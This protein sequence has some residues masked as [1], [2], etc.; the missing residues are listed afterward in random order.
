MLYTVPEARVALCKCSETNQTYG[1]RF[2]KSDDGWKY[3]W[4][5]KIKESSA[6]RENYD[7]TVLQG[8]LTLGEDYPGCPY[9]GAKYFIVCT[10]GK[11]SCNSINRKSNSV[12]CE[13]CGE[14]G[15]ITDYYG[16]GVDSET[17]R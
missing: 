13:W 10:C 17:D 11:L 1:V 14:T 4:A 5:F 3:T 6:R 15:T 12:T 16:A 9:C 2:E 7:R 8:D